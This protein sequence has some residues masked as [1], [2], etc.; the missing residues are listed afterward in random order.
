MNSCSYQT[1]RIPHIHECTSKHAHLV[2]GILVSFLYLTSFFPAADNVS[3][4]DALSQYFVSFRAKFA[5]YVTRAFQYTQIRSYSPI[6]MRKAMK[7]SCRSLHSWGLSAKK[8]LLGHFSIL[9]VSENIISSGNIYWEVIH[10]HRIHASSHCC[11]GCGDWR[12]IKKAFCF[13]VMIVKYWI[14]WELC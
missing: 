11:N 14:G 5:L 8:F 10:P 4:S 6:V 3:Y 9:Y 13:I 2:W 7:F 1:N 12:K